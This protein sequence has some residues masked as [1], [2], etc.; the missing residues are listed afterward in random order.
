[1]PETGNSRMSEYQKDNS[2][3]LN[4]TSAYKLS[5]QISLDGF[6]FFILDDNNNRLLA[7]KKTTVTISNENFISRRFTE[8]Q[9][10]EELLKKDFRQVEVMYFSP[11]FTWV[12]QNYYQKEKNYRLFE[13][14]F[15]ETESQKLIS[16]PATDSNDRLLFAVPVDLTDFIKQ[17]FNNLSLNHPVCALL[18]GLEQADSELDNCLTVW[19]GV[20]DFYLVVKKNKKV[21]VI[22]VFS[23]IAGNDI[24]YYIISAL[25]QLE[26]SP[27]KSHLFLSG[28]LDKVGDLIVKIN[29]YF[30]EVDYLG[31]NKELR[32]NP[33]NVVIPKHQL[34]SLF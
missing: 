24:L 29:A 21:Q 18:K 33:E 1:M 7:W 28:R 20:K 32:F 10:S 4:N 23:Y 25:K 15:P 2:F 34:I 22:N 26:I 30:A 6:S 27:N 12:P 19:I 9:E 13:T 11:Q 3:D 5:I 17:S 16:V 14:L 31:P 8:W